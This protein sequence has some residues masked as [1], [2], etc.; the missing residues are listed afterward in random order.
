MNNLGSLKILSILPPLLQQDNDIIAASKALDSANTKNLS[1]A[2]QLNF[3]TNK[4]LE[5]DILLDVLAYDFHVDFYDKSYSTQIKKQLINDSLLIHAKK[6]TA[7][8]VEELITT[9]FGEGVVEE[10]FEYDGEPFHFRVITNNEEVTTA[11]AQEFVE[12][13]ESVKRKTAILD[14]V[15]INQVEEMNIYVGFAVHFGDKYLFKQ[16]V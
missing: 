4:N 7:Q 5:N 9:V 16:V 2:M 8:S 13:L 12:A 3:F 11:R 14:S 10:W 6:G 1:I 15:T